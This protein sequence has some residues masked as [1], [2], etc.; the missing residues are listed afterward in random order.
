MRLGYAFA[1]GRKASEPA[2]AQYFPWLLAD[3][4]WAGLP[5]A[6]VSNRLDCKPDCQQRAN[7]RFQIRGFD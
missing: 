2:F 5:T 1:Q 7:H 6:F 3:L 4:N